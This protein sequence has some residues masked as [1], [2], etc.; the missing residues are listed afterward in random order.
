MTIARL[1]AL[2]TVTFFVA[3]VDTTA[4]SQDW[5]Q[6]QGPQRNGVWSE[7]NVIDKFPEGGPRVLWRQAIAGGYAGPAVAQG[8]VVVMDYV[9]TSGD[10]TPSPGKA[11]ELTGRER[12]LCLNAKT[13][14]ILWT[15]EY[16]CPYKISYPAGPRATPVIDEGLVFTLGAEGNLHCVN[17][18]DGKPVW[19]K[20]LKRDYGLGLAPHWGFA[21]HPLVDGE[22]LYCV[23]GG[24]GSIAVAFDKRT[25]VEKWRAL[26]SESTGYC[27]PT[28]VEIGG[29]KQL[30]IWHPRSINGLNP[31][32]GE[33]FWSFEIKPAYD[34]SIIAPIQYESYLLA[35]ALQ[36]TSILLELDPDNSTAREVWRNR[37]IHSD[38]NPPLVVDGYLYGVS[39]RGPL[40]CCKLDT[41][42]KIW[43]SMATTTNGRPQ[44]STT[45]FIVRNGHHFYIA[46]EVGELI[47]ATMSPQGYEELDRAKIL[48]PTGQ[49]GNR[50]V[51]WS[52]PAFANQCVYWRNDKEIVCVSLAAEK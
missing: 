41:G 48:E 3:A 15:H 35:T 8:K 42:E 36:G 49:T 34:M 6:W 25:G 13:G 22:T 2:G 18:S 26:S 40:F 52:H 23:V 37:G 9:R 38:H 11:S 29:R 44:N 31:E 7:S 30:V 21:A 14:E 45:G 28:M 46:N 20:E 27:P 32:T 47:I 17:L 16:D 12:V 1:F 50:D 5:N 24:E 4:V 51:V 43:E 39:E 19:S 33:V 10:P